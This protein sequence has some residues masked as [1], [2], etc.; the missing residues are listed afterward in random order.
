MKKCSEKIATLSGDFGIESVGDVFQA[1]VREQVREIIIG[2][3]AE[4]VESLCGPKHGKKSNGEFYRAGSAPGYILHEGRRQ[5]L[6]RPRVRRKTPAGSREEI[7]ISYA[8][9]QDA[10]EL[11][12]RMLSALK[13]GVSG[14]EQSSLHDKSTPGT[15]KSTVSRLW[16]QEGEKVLSTFRSRAIDRA[17]CLVLMLDGVVLE[18]DLVAV[19]ALGVATDGTKM[20][21]DFELGAT[22]NAE[23]AKNLLARLTNRGFAPAKA[24]RLRNC[25]TIP[26]L[27][28]PASSVRIGLPFGRAL[29]G[30]GICCSR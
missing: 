27:F 1:F 4:E 26:T 20:L 15:S 21:L 2:V 12:R 29:H 7:L 13:A 30:D 25:P 10:G 23:T 17:D 28:S 6:K 8:E 24:C 5:E 22:E 18:R 19:V 16:A 14:R 9:A 11:R 3:M